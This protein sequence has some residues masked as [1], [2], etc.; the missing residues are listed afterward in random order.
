[1]AHHGLGME[2]ELRIAGWPRLPLWATG[3]AAAER[4]SCIAT[5]TTENLLCQGTPVGSKASQ[6]VPPNEVAEFPVD[7]SKTSGTFSVGMLASK[8]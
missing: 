6:P 4:G 2:M 3:A 1:M 7:Y 5:F 8:K